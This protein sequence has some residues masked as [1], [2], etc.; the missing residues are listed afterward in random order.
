MDAVDELIER[1]KNTP[2]E[3]LDELTEE[4]MWTENSC[5]IW[6]ANNFKGATRFYPIYK[7]KNYYS[8]SPLA[9]IIHKGN[10]YKNH[11]AIEKVSNT[12]FQYYSGMDTID[13]EIVRIGGPVKNKCIIKSTKEYSQ[14]L[15][16][17]MIKDT[18]KAESKNIGYINILLC[19]GK[20]SLNL[21]LLPW[22][23]PVIIASAPPNYEYV[24]NFLSDNGLNYELVK[25][26]DNNDSLIKCEILINCCRN[27]LEHCRWGFDLKRLSNEFDGKV[28]FWKGQLGDTFMTDYWKIYSH[29]PNVID[30]YSSYLFRLFFGRGRYFLKQVLEKIG[31]TKRLFFWSLW[32]RGAMWQGAH[33]SI[34]RHLTDAL[35]LSG[36]HGHEVQKVVSEVDLRNAVQNDV[37]PRI[38]KILYGKEVKYPQENPGPPPSE[39]RHNISHFKPFVDLL[40]T[41]EITIYN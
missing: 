10:F 6:K 1:Q 13:K 9:L 4:K 36:Y 26:D 29:P 8:Y 30:K 37:R 14:R 41:I 25:L 38:G 5:L 39:I 31:L 7:Y 23:N 33:M 35:V 2:I 11:S 28:I 15:A 40:S 3:V 21:A 19:G 34:I 20:D 27:N 17:A 24:K 12:D 32:H 22:K 16:L 18:N